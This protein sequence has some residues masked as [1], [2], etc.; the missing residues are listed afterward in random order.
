MGG[1]CDSFPRIFVFAWCHGRSEFRA[2][3]CTCANLT[4]NTF[5]SIPV[6]EVYQGNLYALLMISERQTVYFTKI[7]SNPQFVA[8]PSEMSQQSALLYAVAGA[9]E[10]G[11]RVLQKTIRD[12]P[13]LEESRIMRLVTELPNIEREWSTHLVAHYFKES[14]NECTHCL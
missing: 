13:P 7:L 11:T 10:D 4:I 8:L 14:N 3:K 1:L 6:V 5:P 12:A 9:S 2:C